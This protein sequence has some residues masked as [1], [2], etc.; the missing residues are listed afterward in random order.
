MFKRED[1]SF[2]LYKTKNEHN[3]FVYEAA[4]I[5]E[6]LKQKMSEL[7]KKNPIEPVSEAIEKVILEA[8]EQ[9]ENEE[10]LLKDILQELGT[11]NGMEQRLY[12]VRD[13]M[14][15]KMPR[16]RGHFNPR[17]L[18][19]KMHGNK[20]EKVEI[21]DSENI[22]DNWEDLINKNNPESPY[23]WNRMSK[24]MKEHEDKGDGQNEEN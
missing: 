16:G 13:H 19:S 5:A 8:K 4:V 21:L 3:H 11:D 1:G 9:Y 7:V 18:L 2:F 10:I 12:R 23:F 15:G 24:E 22:E 14:I 17:Q 6:E 20:A